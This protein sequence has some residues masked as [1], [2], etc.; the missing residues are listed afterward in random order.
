MPFKAFDRVFDDLTRHLVRLNRLEVELN[1]LWDFCSDTYFPVLLHVPA[2]ADA[3]MAENQ[4][5]LFYP[6][7]RLRSC[8][9]TFPP[10][11]QSLALDHSYR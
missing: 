9:T 5:M 8:A 10:S 3:A 4:E 11:R 2:I 6:G 1:S 7:R